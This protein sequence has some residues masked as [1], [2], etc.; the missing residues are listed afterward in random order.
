[1]LRAHVPRQIADLAE[2]PAAQGTPVPGRRPRVGG[3]HV[4]LQLFVAAEH[5]GTVLAEKVHC[6]YLSEKRRALSSIKY[7]DSASIA[8][9][10]STQY[11]IVS[12]DPVKSI[13]G[14]LLVN[15]NLS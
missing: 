10:E 2:E 9:Q 6:L 14:F 1:V 5:F 13:I 12:S 7:Y 15:L 4:I 8:I 11:E 3:L